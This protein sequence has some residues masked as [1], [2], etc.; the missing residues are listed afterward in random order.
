[1]EGNGSGIL[2]SFSDA[3]SAVAEGVSPHVVRVASDHG[4]GTGVVWSP[5]GYVITCDHIV[6]RLGEVEVTTADGTTRKGMVVGR[7]RD[8]DIAVVKVEGDGLS[9]IAVAD[10]SGVK[11]GQFVMAFANPAGRQPGL[12]SGILTSVNG[13][14]GR[15]AGGLQGTLLLTDARLNPGYSGGPLVDAGGRMIGLDV[16]YFARRGV[17]IPANAVKEVAE[18]LLKDGKIKRAFLG[19]VT[20]DIELPEAIA[21]RK[22]IGQERGMLVMSVETGSPAKKAGLALGDVIIGI[23]DLKVEDHPSLKGALRDDAIGRP[24]ELTVLRA[25]TITKLKVVPGEAPQ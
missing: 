24:T 3:I 1:M 2:Q 21:S 25:E 11:V 4:L 23:G 16:A 13:Q 12:T 8:T 9:P 6:G 18:K 17:A 5:E 22:D 14:I 7:D 20:E 10:S 19:I 15:W